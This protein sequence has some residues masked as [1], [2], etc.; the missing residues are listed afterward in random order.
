MVVILRH[1]DTLLSRLFSRIR[2]IGRGCL[3][4]AC[5]DSQ[6]VET[7]FLLSRRDGPLRWLRGLFQP[8][9]AAEMFAAGR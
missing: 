8:L 3:C 5:G 2:V 1:R 7:S 6:L 4:D 9:T